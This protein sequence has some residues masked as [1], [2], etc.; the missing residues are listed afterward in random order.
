MC[1]LVQ[2][3]D[4]SPEVVSQALECL[5]RIGVTA[6]SLDAV[7]A[8]AALQA[9]TALGRFPAH[10]TLKVAGVAEKVVPP[11]ALWG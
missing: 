2:S 6:H 9:L 5:I 7:G 1:Q 8:D 10:G 4:T 11:T 3:T